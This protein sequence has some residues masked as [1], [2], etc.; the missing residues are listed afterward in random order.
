MY[1]DFPDMFGPVR[2]INEIV[3]SDNSIEFGMKLPLANAFS[4]IGCRPLRT[5][6]KLLLSTEGRVYPLINAAWAKL[7]STSTR[8]K[9]LAVRE[10]IDESSD[11]RAHISWKRE[12]S[13]HSIRSCAFKIA[14][15]WSLSS[16]VI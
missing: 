7:V 9:A 11:N 16:G 14:F 6:R 12:V 10:R 5:L 8:A 1:V 3:S 15:S 2:S 13:N 4:T